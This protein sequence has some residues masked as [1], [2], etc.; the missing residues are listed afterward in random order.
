MNP[1]ELLVSK[2]LHSR[3]EL[4]ALSEGELLKSMASH[5]HCWMAETIPADCLR[6]EL[7][8]DFPVDYARQRNILP[9]WMEDRVC[10]LMADPSDV[11]ALQDAALL[12]QDDPQPVVAMA[13]EIRRAID[14]VYFEQSRPTDLELEV[15]PGG[16]T[17]TSFD[18]D[19]LRSSDDAPVTR[20]VNS[21]LLQAL[22]ENASDIHI[23]PFTRRLRL[24]YRIDGI[25]REQEDLPKG[26]E[27]SLTSRLKIMSRLDIA[28]KRLPQDGTARVVVG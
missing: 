20:L 16:Q 17:G 25:L 27:A 1:V 3:D 5:F 7:L 15:S 18:G 19:L 8:A 23:E 26:L 2:G 10:L 13:E 6:P 12:L 21:V 28:E 11:G 22:Q 9:V 4:E 24:R 14:T